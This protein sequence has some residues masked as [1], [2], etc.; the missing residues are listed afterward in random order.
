[1]KS[2]MLTFMS[3]HALGVMGIAL[4]LAMTPVKDFALVVVIAEVINY[5]GCC[6]KSDKMYLGEIDSFYL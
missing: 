1:M 2:I 5:R 6:R 4:A 3:Q